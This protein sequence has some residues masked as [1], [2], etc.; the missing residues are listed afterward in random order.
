MAK[1]SVS[2][3]RMKS[4]KWTMEQEEVKLSWEEELESKQGRQ[5][6]QEQGAM[7]IVAFVVETVLSLCCPIEANQRMSMESNIA[8]ERSLRI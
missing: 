8:D 4:Q 5:G 1:S 7:M 2:S 3:R 6:R